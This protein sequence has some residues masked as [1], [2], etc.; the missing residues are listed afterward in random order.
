MAKQSK[1][2]KRKK[3]Q[4]LGINGIRVKLVAIILV[5]A[6][7]PLILM[8]IFTT[9]SMKTTVMELETTIAEQQLGNAEKE[10][11]SLIDGTFNG[12]DILSKNAAFDAALLDPTPENLAAAKNAI[13]S[14]QD[15]FPQ[16][17]TAE[18]LFGKDG[19]QIVRGDDGDLND[20][21]DREYA[22]KALEGTKY[23]SDVLVSKASGKAMVYMSDPVLDSQDNILGGFA[24]SSYPDELSE[25]IASIVDT[26]TDITVLDRVGTIVATTEE[27]YDL[28][29]GEAIDLSGEEYYKLAQSSGEGVLTTTHNGKKVLLSYMLEP[30]TNW[31]IACITDYNTVIE[32]YVRSLRVSLLIM[33]V[34]LIVVVLSGFFFAKNIAIPIVQ[35]K[36]FAE[37]LSKGDFTVEPLN[38]HRN[39]EIGQMAD[40]LN[41]MYRSNSSVIF[42]IGE[43]SGK[44]SDSSA[45]LSETSQDLL[46]RFEEVASSMERVNDA[47]TSTGA[48]T[49]EV[50]ASAN[51]VNESVERLAEE[52]ENTKREV[53][54]I[55]KKAAEIEK[56]GRESSEYAIRIAKERGRELEEATEAAKVVSEIATMADSIAGI[57]NQI[58]LLSLNASIE[59]A[60]AGEHGRGFAVVAGEI[61]NLA[62]QTKSSVEQIQATVD[63]IQTAFD[64][65]Q[66]S[67]SEL[68]K[69][70][71]DTVAPDYNKFITIGQEYGADARKFGE[72]AD[73]ISE[74]V[75]YISDSMEQV[76]AAV[77]D[78]AESAT[79]TA[80]SS[81]EVTDTIGEAAN[82][83][84]RMSGMA[85]DSQEVSHHLDEIVKQFKLKD[86]GDIM[87]DDV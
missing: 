69:F 5:L 26:H 85:N 83:M 49:E 70:L 20:I 31:T 71:R 16:G 9:H 19:M 56:E 44:V 7:V 47:M 25:G 24:K 10:V 32:P 54:E 62:A 48:A 45:E 13:V 38:I 18:F 67:S 50:S 66:S 78:I 52:T 15:A 37:T 35:V 36:E 84:E 34:A 51:E 74:M 65:L 72:L 1:S 46:A 41:R 4:S 30:T 42:N 58:N 55:S 81:A 76:N 80:G 17:A 21:S 39:D 40:S 6:V 23:L 77:S 73:N 63:K 3:S 79:E 59:A 28:A 12:V 33:V 22:K 64:S 29:S 87:S 27:Q 43:G 57:A 60:R 86:G 14:A 75:G 11:V 82:M 2:A 53:V 61:N 8:T 68:L